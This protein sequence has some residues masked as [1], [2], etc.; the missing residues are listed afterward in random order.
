MSERTRESGSVRLRL[1]NWGAPALIVVLVAFCFAPVLGNE[2]VNW[3]DP[4]YFLENTRYRGLSSAHLAWMF[5]TLDFSHYQPLTWLTHGLVYTGWGMD[6]SG[7]HLGNLALHAAN[8]VL[9]YLLLLQLLRVAGGSTATLA[10]TVGALFFALHPLRVEAVAWATERQEV[11][12]AC[13]LLLALIAY[14]RMQAQQVGSRSR[15]LWYALSVGW[16]TLSLL[17]KAA[18]MM[19]PIVLLALDVYPLR[20]F[21]TV[22][23]GARLWLVLEKVPYALA[24]T[25]A[26]VL[27][28]YAKQSFF[29]RPLAQHGMTER[30]MQSMYGLC[31]YVWKTV[32]PVH[33]SPLYLL[34]RPMNPS[35]PVY[36]ACAAAVVAVT[37]TL[38]VLR[39]RWP[40]ALQAWVCYVV[41]LFPVIGITQS[42][43]QK[44]ADRYTYLGCLPWVVLVAAAVQRTCQSWQ[45]GRLSNAA[46]YGGGAALVA[47]LVTL[48][49][50]TTAQT[51]VWHDS[52]TLWDRA[53]A[54]EPDNNIAYNNRGT[55][56][57]LKGDVS[58]ARADYE[59]A[60]RLHP[61]HW[62]ARVNRA[63][64]R[65]MMGD[66][67]GAIA[68]Y[69]EL[70]RRSP[71]YAYGYDARGLARAAKSDFDGAVSDYRT[72]LRL[73]PPGAASRTAIEAHLA[74]AQRAHAADASPAH[75]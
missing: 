37:A 16:F 33:L 64:A 39:R 49:M 2:F 20:R 70:I 28:F 73:T 69:T 4:G 15:H 48:G 9:C 55:G 35:D 51:R 54:V 75:P 46:A 8:A 74:A 66:F 6:P 43:P 34:E 22:R 25:A 63:W 40:W 50:L 24:A 41:I 61:L 56:K 38:V 62:D 68:D 18:G 65:R 57:Q 23:R 7:Y 45:R 60:V 13:F 19:L 21:A 58:G 3:D 36:V 29:M 44:V 14:L 17:S 30:I 31:F 32:L 52:V 26:A 59:V 53:I 27:A 67:D 47:V 11:L 71:R 12:S 72:A 5:T 10:A 1:L 42:G